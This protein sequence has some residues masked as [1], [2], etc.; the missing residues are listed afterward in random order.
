[1]RFCT[2]KR[3]G[4]LKYGEVEVGQETVIFDSDS[5][6]ADSGRADSSSDL[7]IHS[8]PFRNTDVQFVTRVSG[9]SSDFFSPRKARNVPFAGS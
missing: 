7:T 9:A 2:S 4:D 5:H 3:V 8:L 1:M 6:A